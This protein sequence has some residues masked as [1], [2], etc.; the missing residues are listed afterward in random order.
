MAAVQKSM[1]MVSDLQRQ[2]LQRIVNTLNVRGTSVQRHTE[3]GA[4]HESL[5]VTCPYS[6][7]YIVFLLVLPTVVYVPWSKNLGMSSLPCKP[8][9]VLLAPVFV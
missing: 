1:G 2:A 9:S 8:F 7:N 6:T 4:K 3:A 5:A